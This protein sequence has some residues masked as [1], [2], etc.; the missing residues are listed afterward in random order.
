MVLGLSVP[1]NVKVKIKD[2]SFV[3]NNWTFECLEWAK[4]AFAT[5]K[6]PSGLKNLDALIANEDP[7]ATITCFYHIIKDNE[8]SIEDFKLWVKKLT[9]KEYNKIVRAMFDVIKISNPEAVQDYVKKKRPKTIMTILMT[10]IL[11]SLI[12]FVVGIVIVSNTSIRLP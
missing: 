11:T 7:M 9:I 1:K 12:W 8:E 3:L 4:E 10:A 6:N 5:P 2:R